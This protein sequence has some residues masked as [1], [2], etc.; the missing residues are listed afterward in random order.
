MIKNLKI[1]LFV[2]LLFFI[3]ILISPY[4]DLKFSDFVFNDGSGFKNVYL[5]SFFVSITEVGDSF[6][7]FLISILGYFFCYIFIKPL[8]KILNV[9]YNKLRDFF[10]FLFSATLI[11]GVL[12]QII[13]HLVGRPRPNYALENNT[14]GVDFFSLESS[15]HS[16]P[17]GHTSTVFIVAFCLA[18][19][20][21]KLKYFYFLFAGIV[22]FSR[23]V[24]GAHYLFDV[25]SGAVVALIGLK[26]TLIIFKKINKIENI[27]TSKN[28]NNNSFLLVLVVF[29]IS[30]SFVTVGNDI[31]IFISSLFYDGKQSF[32]IQSYFWIS[33]LSRKIFLPLLVLYIIIFPFISMYLPV[34]KIYLSYKFSIKDVVFVF[35]TF[36]FNLVFIVNYVLKANWG[37]VR[38]NEILQL[39][40][41]ENFT[42][43]YEYSS[44][45]NTNCSFV[46][47][48]ASVGFSLIALFFITKNKFFLWFSL[49]VGLFL[50]SIR[51]MEG[52][53]FVSDIL[54]AGLLIYVLSFVQ[55]YFYNSKIK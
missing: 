21:P 49:F 31:D 26:I 55:F 29:F 10:L 30:I 45:C 15:F 13:K 16:F 22:G 8:K 23:I 24:V 20:T 12:T 52:G 53:H 27:K 34:K 28:F 37:R 44:I 33:I 42:A 39:G 2:F 7:F 3:N 47:G 40:G 38:P 17:S 48:D 25:L 5:K 43:W 46:S 32:L 9:G 41:K 19:F 51:I 11:T 50:G 1:E 54:F 14:Y 36:V 4:L 35:F 18:I 6:W